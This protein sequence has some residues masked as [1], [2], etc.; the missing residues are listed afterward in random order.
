MRVHHHGKVQFAYVI[1]VHWAVY[2]LFAD[3]KVAGSAG[4]HP[5]K[6]YPPRV[7]GVGATRGLP[8]V[9]LIG[10]TEVHQAELNVRV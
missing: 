9:P 10:L 7:G 6:V 1:S 2:V 5:A 4:N 3:G 8:A